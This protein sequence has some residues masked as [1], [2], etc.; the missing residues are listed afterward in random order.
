MD[1]H[2][3]LQRVFPKI[4]GDIAVTDIDNLNT[5]NEALIITVFLSVL[6]SVMMYPEQ[7]SSR[8]QSAYDRCIPLANYTELGKFLICDIAVS[9]HQ[10]TSFV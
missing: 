5:A 1:I 9:S 3:C 2:P 6:L 4:G 7:L 10:P 8:S